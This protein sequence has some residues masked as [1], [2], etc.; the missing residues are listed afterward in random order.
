MSRVEQVLEA[1]ELVK[2]ATVGLIGDGV[3]FIEHSSLVSRVADQ[4][5]KLG[6]ALPAWPI[7]V[8]AVR[9]QEGY[10]IGSTHV[11][12]PNRPN[13]FVNTSKVIDINPA[14]DL[15]TELQDAVEDFANELKY[16][17]RE[18]NDQIAE[19]NDPDS[20]CSTVEGQ[21]ATAKGIGS[22]KAIQSR[23]LA[24]IIRA[25]AAELKAIRDTLNADYSEIW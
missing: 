8:D 18:L 19:S 6:K 12:L 20:C 2:A 3:K 17:I 4:A 16:T 1:Q 15:V 9:A 23:E 14:Q 13:L 7:V 22:L 11:T 10:S 24:S 5:A 21:V 25:R